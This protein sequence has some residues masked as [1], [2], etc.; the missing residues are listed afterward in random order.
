MQYAEYS[1][2]NSKISIRK[3]MWQHISDVSITAKVKTAI[4]TDNQSFLIMKLSV[5]Y[6]NTT[7]K[8]N[9]TKMH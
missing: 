3:K 1:I 4:T 6:I 5:E 7:D 9:V 2:V 8:K